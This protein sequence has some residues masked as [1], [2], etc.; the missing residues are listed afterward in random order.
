VG[1]RVNAGTG[2]ATDRGRLLIGV[3]GI[4]FGVLT[5]ALLVVDSMA[6]S[7]SSASALTS[8]RSNAN[9]FWAEFIVTIALAAVG[10][11]FFAGLGRIL[12]PRSPTLVNGVVLLVVTGVFALVIFQATMTMGLWAVTQGPTGGVY[13]S[14][15]IV[16]AAFAY[17]FASEAIGVAFLLWGVGLLLASWAFWGSEIFPK[18]LSVLT[19]LGGLSAILAPV[20]VGPL[21]ALDLAL[22]AVSA[23]VFAVIGFT[24]GSLVLR[25]RPTSA[26]E[27]SPGVGSAT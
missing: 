25:T 16:Q 6:P 20:M 26:K 27:P 7:I 10:I 9:I 3:L 2:V 4:V 19:L 13:A 1:R 8:Y 23:I 14:S 22:S 17:N 21:S 12:S 15:A 18:W 5:L 24:S 11:P